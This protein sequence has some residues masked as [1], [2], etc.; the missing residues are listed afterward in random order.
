MRPFPARLCASTGSSRSLENTE[1]SAFKSEQHPTINN[2]ADSTS[3]PL[4]QDERQA[5]EIV[6][7]L[8]A[9]GE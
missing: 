3:Q 2:R 5:K 1:N 9:T 7:E 6:T 8:D 4:T